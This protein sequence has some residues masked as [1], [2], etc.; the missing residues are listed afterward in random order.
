MWKCNLADVEVIWNMQGI[1][2]GKSKIKGGIMRVIITII[3]NTLNS[4]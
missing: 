3:T 4:M 1:K 2:A